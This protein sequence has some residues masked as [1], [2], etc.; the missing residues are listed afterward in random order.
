MSRIALLAMSLSLAPAGGVSAQTMMQQAGDVAGQAMKATNDMVASGVQMFGL[1]IP[2]L[3]RRP[4][5]QP[6]HDPYAGRGLKVP[7][8]AIGNA[9]G[10]LP[11]NPDPIPNGPMSAVSLA[12]TASGLSNDGEYHA[13]MPG[14]AGA[15]SGSDA[16]ASAQAAAMAT[17]LVPAYPIDP[18]YP[19]YPTDAVTATSLPQYDSRAVGAPIRPPAY[20]GPGGPVVD[21]Y[22][23]QGVTGGYNPV[24]IGTGS[25]G[26][27]GGIS[28]M[29]SAVTTQ[30]DLQRTGEIAGSLGR[31]AATGAMQLGEAATNGVMNLVNGQAR[32]QASSYGYGYAQY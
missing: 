30:I 16:A 23:G 18:A 8:V 25:G 6:V 14:E 17:A 28:Q 29:S 9:S 26:I 3:S 20:G 5:A 27:V 21:V 13:P 22:P 32:T 31:S 12:A 11:I 7:S 24:S 4:T 1:Q 10:A 19:P 15:G 2:G